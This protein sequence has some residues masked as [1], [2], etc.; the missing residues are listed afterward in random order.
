MCESRH[1]DDGGMD[2]EGLEDASVPGGDDAKQQPGEEDGGQSC[3][4]HLPFLS[5][6]QEVSAVVAKW[7]NQRKSFPKKR[8]KAGSKDEQEP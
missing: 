4:H 7:R 6:R 2:E 3:C 5:S 8:E 1:E